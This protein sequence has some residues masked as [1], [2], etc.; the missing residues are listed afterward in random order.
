MTDWAVTVNLGGEW[1]DA[2]RK[3][4]MLVWTREALLARRPAIV[5]AHP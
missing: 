2:V 5:F 4:G 1:Q 3:E